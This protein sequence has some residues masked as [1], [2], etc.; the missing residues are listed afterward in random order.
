MEKNRKSKIKNQ[1]SKIGKSKNLKSKIEDSKI[2]FEYFLYFTPA[3][4]H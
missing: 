2:A 4:S 3:F 1:K